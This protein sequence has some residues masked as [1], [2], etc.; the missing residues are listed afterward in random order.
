MTA[1]HIPYFLCIFMVFVVHKA[2][3]TRTPLF[4]SH[5]TYTQGLPCHTTITFRAH[6]NCV[7]H[8]SGQQL[9]T[10]KWLLHICQNILEMNRVFLPN[11]EKILRNFSLSKSSPK[12]L[13]YTLVNSIAFAPNSASRSLRDLKCPTKLHTE[14]RNMAQEKKLW[15]FKIWMII[16]YRS[17]FIIYKQ[18]KIKKISCRSPKGRDMVISCSIHFIH[19]LKF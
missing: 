3:A 12:F 6:I 19:L 8:F 7:C 18:I 5:H 11:T 16:S 14:S 15:K 13:M 1:C 17:Q 4:I 2:K 9:H 10:W